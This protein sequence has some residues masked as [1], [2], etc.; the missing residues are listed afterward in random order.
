MKAEL[1]QFIR[2]SVEQSLLTGERVAYSDDAKTV[3]GIVIGT[4]GQPLHNS[5]R[6]GTLINV[7][8]HKNHCGDDLALV[9]W[10]DD[11]EPTTIHPCWIVSVQAE[12]T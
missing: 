4:K 7:G 5:K 9:L 6:I 3:P 8:L 2:S 11:D 10:D 12:S 1:R